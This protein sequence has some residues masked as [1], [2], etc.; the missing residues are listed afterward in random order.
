MVSS[1]S[2]SGTRLWNWFA[3]ESTQWIHQAPFALPEGLFSSSTV[4]GFA[5]WPL[6]G[7]GAWGTFSMNSR[8]F[9]GRNTTTFLREENTP[10]GEKPKAKVGPCLSLVEPQSSLKPRQS[11]ASQFLFDSR[12]LWSFWQ[13]LRDW[14][15]VRKGRMDSVSQLYLNATKRT[16]YL[17]LHF[18]GF[19][20]AHLST[21]VS[22]TQFQFLSFSNPNMTDHVR[23][24]LMKVEV[25]IHS[26]WLS[27]SKDILC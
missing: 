9:L 17:H 14:K 7:L 3:P 8:W 25:S 5:Q 11:A 24:A 10:S 18:Y 19:K 6:G 16:N 21:T 22:Y 12:G 27:H 20:E 4:R 26:K 15:N 23:P 2:V 1:L 13:I